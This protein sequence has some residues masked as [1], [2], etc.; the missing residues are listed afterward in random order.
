MGPLELG[1][2]PAR[3]PAFGSESVPQD[4][5][6]K[7]KV[8]QGSASRT[9]GH[10]KRTGVHVKTENNVCAEDRPRPGPASPGP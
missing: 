6:E 2:K 1:V 8:P 5:Q 10:L 7:E 4:K 9:E 3:L